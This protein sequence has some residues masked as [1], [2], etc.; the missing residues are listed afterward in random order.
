M[1]FTNKYERYCDLLELPY[2]FAHSQLK[3][4]YY[5][6]ALKYHPD[7][8]KGDDD[9]FKEINEAYTFLNENHNSDSDS[10]SNFKAFSNKTKFVEI[11]TEFINSYDQNNGWSDLFIQ[12]T[13]N[14]ILKHCETYSEQLFKDLDKKKSQELYSFIFKYRELFSISDKA[15]NKIK[16]IV[17]EKMKNDNI[18]ILNPSIDDLLLD[19]VYKLELNEDCFYVPLWHKKIEFY[20]SD[21]AII[22]KNIPELD[23]NLRIDD[24]NNLFISLE[25]DIK[26][27]LTNKYYIYTVGDAE[28]KIKAEQLTITE[29]TQFITF[30]ERGILQL[31]KSNM[32]DSSKR[33]DVIFEINLW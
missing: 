9:L 4:R 20:L 14:N 5:K 16:R 33:G 6:M 7:K 29:N 18:I 28:F 1:E 21:T 12:T 19:K 17:Q 27:I 30:R 25:I 22:V 26:D 3:K 8:Y 24:N 15:I 23:R 10:F 2:N 13:I 31:V 32:F 11:I